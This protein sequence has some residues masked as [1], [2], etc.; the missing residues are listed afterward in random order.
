M[1]E[2]V[3]VSYCLR[4]ILTLPGITN[5]S[6][7]IRAWIKNYIKI[8]EILI[9]TEEEILSIFLN[10]NQE[11]EIKNDSITQPK[12][13]GDVEKAIDDIFKITLS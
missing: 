11:V 2:F 5:P 12:L 8:T 10:K 4:W 1:H 9:G 6:I 3:R 7:S 13:I